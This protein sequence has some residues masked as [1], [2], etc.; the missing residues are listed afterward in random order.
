MNQQERYNTL[1]QFLESENVFRQYINNVSNC[2]KNNFLPNETTASYIYRMC[3]STKCTSVFYD[4]F[5]W[6]S[7]EE[8][9]DF[10]VSM[11]YKWET[12]FE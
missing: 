7:T 12:Q 11:K 10:W 3:E 5:E 2:A 6:A 1:I 9:F 4:A 8:G